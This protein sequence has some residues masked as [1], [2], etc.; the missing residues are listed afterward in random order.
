MPEP[1]PPPIIDAVRAQGFAALP[2]REARHLFDEPGTALQGAAWDSFAASW[3]D[4]RPD[5]HMAD[6]GRYRLRRGLTH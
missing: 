6:H 2:A 5:R 1:I 3:D 4:L